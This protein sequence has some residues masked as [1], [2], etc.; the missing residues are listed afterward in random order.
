MSDNNINNNDINNTSSNFWV[1][2]CSMRFI[3]HL[4]GPRARHVKITDDTATNERL[5]SDSTDI[6]KP[7]RIVDDAP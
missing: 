2:A 6:W 1:G 3:I 7:G 5:V 4:P